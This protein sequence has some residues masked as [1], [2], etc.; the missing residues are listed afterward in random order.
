MDR[1]KM[2][3]SYSP[4]MKK[5]TFII[6]LGILL[7]FLL[8]TIT[9]HPDLS[10]I[11]LAGKIILDGHWLNF[12][13]SNTLNQIVFNYPPLAFL[14]PSLFYLPFNSFL[15]SL[16]LNL[17]NTS[18]AFFSLHPVYLP[19][20]IFKL[21]MILADIAI[22]FLLPNLFVKPSLKRLSQVLWALNPIAIFVSSMMGQVDIILVVFLV[23]SLIFIK[24]HHLNFAAIFIGLS[25]LIKP[26]GL[27][28]LP[29]LFIKEF[30]RT[31][32]I[33]YSL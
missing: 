14:I 31:K 27:I 28:L 12:Y 26:A 25:I 13:D 6:V 16:Y 15:S 20:L 32:K 1:S 8:S 18:P 29:L 21:P 11:I 17:V 4:Q 3:E 7:R 10:A 23:I 24:R 19:L 5:T 2:A 30:S 33:I 22:I 9:F